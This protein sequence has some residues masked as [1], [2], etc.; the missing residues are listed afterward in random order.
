VYL[1]DVVCE[2]AMFNPLPLPLMHKQPNHYLTK[3]R[4][5]H[6]LNLNDLAFILEI[7]QG[8]LSRFE[9]G[10]LSN[11]KAYAGY[12]IFFNLSIQSSLR[13]VFKGGVKGLINKCF[14]LIERIEDSSKTQR[15]ALRLEG[16]NTI[17]ARL[18][19]YDNEIE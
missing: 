9:A 5:D 7:D 17:I 3:S 6:H 1:L 13:Q 15:N 11:P 19:E 4:K 14:Q 18:M 10:K 8:N 2:K 16:V 12:H